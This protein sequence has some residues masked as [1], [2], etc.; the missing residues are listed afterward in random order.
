LEAIPN[1]SKRIIN[2]YKR[3]HPTIIFQAPHLCTV[4]NKEPMATANCSDKLTNQFLSSKNKI[5]KKNNVTLR[6]NVGADPIVKDLPENRKMMTFSMATTERY[7]NQQGEWQ[8]DTQWHRIVVWGALAEKLATTIEKGTEVIVEG[9]INSRQYTDKEGVTKNIT[10]VIA[11]EVIKTV[12]EAA[13][14]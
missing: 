1:V 10:E 13:H 6:G 8:G 2:V 4:K 14:A 5:M 7:K 3:F 11:T 12:R 9:K